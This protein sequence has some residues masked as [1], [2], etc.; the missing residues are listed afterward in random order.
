M[1]ASYQQYIAIA[2]AFSSLTGCG[3]LPKPFN[4]AQQQLQTQTDALALKTLSVPVSAR[5]TSSE[6]VAHSLKYNLDYR[7]QQLEEIV[8][9]TDRSL[10]SLNMLPNLISTLG[11]VDRSNINAVLSP[12]TGQVSTA[13]DKIRR[14]G[15][16]KFSWN[17]IDFGVSYFESKQKADLVLVAVQKKRKVMQRLAK[18]TR[19]AFWRSYAVARYKAIAYHYEREL[20]TSLSHAQIA[21]K[22][23]LM[24]SLDSLRYQRDLWLLS[25]QI[26]SVSFELARFK[27]ELFSLMSAPLN[28]SPTLIMSRDDQVDPTSILPKRLEQLEQLALYFR[29]ELQEERYRRRIALN[30]VNKARVRLLPGFE[31]NYGGSYDSNSYL[32]NNSWSQLSLSLTWNLIKIY[33]NLKNIQ[34]AKQQGWLADARRIALAMAVVTQVDIAKLGYDFAKENLQTL[35]GVLQ[36]ERFIYTTLKNEKQAFDN[37]FNLTRA[38]GALILAQLRRDMAYADYQSAK[39]DLL[40][41]IGLDPILS[42]EEL[43]LPVKELAKHIAYTG[44]HLQQQ[45][46]LINKVLAEL[47]SPLVTKG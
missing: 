41:S 20:K 1:V 15:D 22:E 9:N 21:Q 36:S 32:V 2:I 8:A 44:A 14:L 3:V 24:A 19:K 4:E 35:E 10:T 30:E 34:F 27:P 43:R 46:K 37:Q 12:I 13:E 39:A 11:Y 7:V 33:A 25:N 6:A 47:N 42:E 28:S 26:L 17:I 23:H 18:D 31:F 38:R 16:L 45:K 40:D 5:L 29:P